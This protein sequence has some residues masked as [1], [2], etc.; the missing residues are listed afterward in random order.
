MIQTMSIETKYFSMLKLPIDSV[1]DES[2]AD[3]Q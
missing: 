2:V 3:L 1:Y